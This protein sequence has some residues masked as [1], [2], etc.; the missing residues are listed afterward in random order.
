VLAL[1]T[2]E[3]GS[4]GVS[5]LRL[6]R[7]LFGASAEKTDKLFPDSPKYKDSA[8]NTDNMDDEPA[9]DRAAAGKER[10]RRSGH[11]RNG[12]DSFTGAVKVCVVQGTLHHGD[13]CPECSKG[14]LYTQPQPAVL[15]RIRG[16]APLS[17]TRYELERLRCNLCGEVFTAAAPDGGGER[18]YDKTAGTMIQ[19]RDKLLEWNLASQPFNFPFVYMLFFTAMRPSEVTALRVA[20]VDAD[21]GLIEIQTSRY[22]GSEAPTKTEHS[23]RTIK[24]LPDAKTVIKTLLRHNSDR[25]NTSSST[26]KT[27][28]RSITA[29]GPKVVGRKR[30]RRRGSGLESSTQ[31]GTPLSAPR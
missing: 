30:S 27:A 23:E 18:N 9:A 17:A 15:V 6:R 20:N 26:P 25:T 31:R 8:G 4:K 2:N 10:K 28:G 7:M 3:I 14:K 11:G 16:M 22:L 12:A 5:I 13:R 1:L 29:S 24:L 21:R 19:E